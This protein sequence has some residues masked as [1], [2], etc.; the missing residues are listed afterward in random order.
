MKINI[1]LL[2]LITL[3]T[4]TVFYLNI[5]VAQE[6]QTKD[7]QAELEKNLSKK[8]SSIVQPANLWFTNF[9]NWLNLPMW[10]VSLSFGSDLFYGDMRQFAWAPMSNKYINDKLIPD[11]DKINENVPEVYKKS[12][13]LPIG[14]SANDKISERKWGGAVSLSKQFG[15]V[16]ALRGSYLFGN[17]GGVSYK[18]LKNPSLMTTYSDQD[19]FQNYPIKVSYYNPY[20]R[21][22]FTAKFH[23]FALDANL[24]LNSLIFPQQGNKLQG[25]LIGGI[26]VMTYTSSF[27]DLKT[28][29]QLNKTQKDINQGYE[30]KKINIDIKNRM[31]PE[32]KKHITTFPVGF[33]FKYHFTPHISA[34]LESTYRLTKSDNIDSRSDYKTESDHYQYTC[35]GISYSIGK[36]ADSLISSKLQSKYKLNK[37]ARETKSKLE[38]RVDSIQKLVGDLGHRV[39]ILEAG[40]KNIKDSIGLMEKRLAEKTLIQQVPQTGLNT[41]QFTATDVITQLLVV[42][43]D[44]NKAI[45]KPAYHERIALVAKI[46][47]YDPKITVQIVG[48]A[49]RIG[50]DKYNMDLSKRRAEVVANELKDAY[51]IAPSRLSNIIVE[52]KKNPLSNKYDDVNRR[53]DFIFLKPIEEPVKNK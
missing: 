52:G 21:N 8:D 10:S 23:E 16:L 11:K 12:L 27:F 37:I 28:G 47:K 40:D 24:Y 35:L 20:L 26:G 14:K 46:M 30:D 7:K 39:G 1:S 25:Y 18:L 43:F 3:L 17:L 22:Y 13:D 29:E 19:P 48:H 53:V 2:K 51:D 4:V 9:V 49:D 33:G 50:S 44:F 34:F 6:P 15:A 42:F 38:A 31:M 5:A 45:I 36:M 41:M 32:Q